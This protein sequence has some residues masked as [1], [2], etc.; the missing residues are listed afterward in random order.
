MHENIVNLSNIMNGIQQVESVN[1]YKQK[2]F[3]FIHSLLG[4]ILEDP[5]FGSLTPHNQKKCNILLEYLSNA[6]N[7][8]D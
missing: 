8:S 1:E 4:D 2:S 5:S 7:D 6:R 3:T